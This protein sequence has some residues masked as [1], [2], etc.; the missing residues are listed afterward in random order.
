MIDYLYKNRIPIILVAA[1]HYTIFLWMY[2]FWML[3]AAGDFENAPIDIV[4]LDEAEVAEIIQDV[5]PEQMTP[6][7]HEFQVENAV[8]NQ[9]ADQTTRAE[10]RA[11]DQELSDEVYDELKQFEADQFAALQEQWEIDHPEEPFEQPV[12]QTD[13]NDNVEISDA[14]SKAVDGTVTVSYFLKGR[15][16]K[17]LPIPAYLC[18]SS[19]TVVV[20][21]KVNQKGKVVAARADETQSN[22]SKE[23]LVEAALDRARKSTFNSDVTA[24]NQQEGTITYVFVSQ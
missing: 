7:L 4:M 19:G 17:N 5:D 18:Q 24:A 15:Y 21:V 14:P 8:A 9:E 1:L 11:N 12:D 22:M 3:P 20:I 13:P 2:F 6:D 16:D 23:C 10:N